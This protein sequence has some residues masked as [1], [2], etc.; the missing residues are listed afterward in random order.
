[1][2]ALSYRTQ[3]ISR[4]IATKAKQT[5]SSNEY[6]YVSVAGLLTATLFWLQYCLVFGLSASLR[7]AA[8][9]KLLPHSKLGDWPE[10][11]WSLLSWLDVMT[12]LNFLIFI[13]P[14]SL[15]AVQPSLHLSRSA[16]PTLSFYVRALDLGYLFFFFFVHIHDF[17]NFLAI[18]LLVLVYIFIGVPL[19]ARLCKMFKGSRCGYSRPSSTSSSMHH[20]STRR[21]HSMSPRRVGS[22]ETLLDGLVDVGN[23]KMDDA[24][25]HDPFL[26]VHP[27]LN[28]S[29]LVKQGLVEEMALPLPVHSAHDIQ[30][31][32][33]P[34][35]E[36]P[37][38]NT[39]TKPAI[40]PL[41]RPKGRR[42]TSVDP[43]IF[44]PNGTRSFDEQAKETGATGRGVVVVSLPPPAYTP[45]PPVGQGRRAG[46]L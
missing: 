21:G 12:Q 6:T 35:D 41:P 39:G 30:G 10:W 46:S 44:S 18:V 19:T 32:Q 1:M 22:E 17:G 31:P 26:V 8:P 16:G 33:S 38:S 7:S 37:L 3:N 29:V 4:N 45:Y 20:T 13:F 28:D 43:L 14:H 2:N 5:Y 25:V 34:C 40:P 42:T 15:A 27:S 36:T 24:L 11:C 23:D 9:F